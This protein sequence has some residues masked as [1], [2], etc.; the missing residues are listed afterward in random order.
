ME[1]K[2]TGLDELRRKMEKLAADAKPE[3]MAKRMSAVR[4][5]VHGESPKNVRVAGNEA[6]AEFCCEK[7]RDLAAAAV[8]APFK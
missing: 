8:R 7:L 3:A 5:P 2:I 1:F 6:H 4:C